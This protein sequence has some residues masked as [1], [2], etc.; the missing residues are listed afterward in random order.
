MFRNQ[1]FFKHAIRNVWGSLHADRSMSIE[2]A[3]VSSIDGEIRMLNVSEYTTYLPKEDEWYNV[4]QIGNLDDCYIGLDLSFD[5]WYRL[6]Y[7]INTHAVNIKVYDDDGR[8]APACMVYMRKLPN[9]NV[10]VAVEI[11]EQ[12]V[13]TTKGKLYMS[14]YDGQ[15]KKTAGYNPN[16]NNVSI[17]SELIV[18][19]SQLQ[20]MINVYREELAK[21]GKVQAYVDGY[22]VAV[23]NTDTA[24]VWQYIDIVRDGLVYKF[25]NIDIKTLKTFDSSLDECRKY[26]VHPS[27][28]ND[29]LNFNNDIEIFVFDKVSGLGMYYYVHYLKDLRQLTHRDLS[30]P[31]DK[32]LTAVRRNAENGHVEKV[33]DLNDLKITL[34][35][36]HSGFPQHLQYEHSL[37]SELYKLDDYLIIDAMAG[38]NSTVHEWVAANLEE[39]DYCKLMGSPFEQITKELVTTT[40][41]YHGITKYAADTPLAPSVDFPK[42]FLLPP[43]TSDSFWVFE[44]NA[45]GLFINKKRIYNRKDDIY[46]AS[47]DTVNYI[48]LIPYDISDSEA[49]IVWNA[50]PFKK[51]NTVNY[52]FYYGKTEGG[53]TLTGEFVDITDDRSKWI[54]GEDGTIDWLFDT[55]RY[56]PIVVHDKW[57]YH[58]RHTDTISTDGLI[59]FTVLPDDKVDGI[60][61]FFCPK[62]MFIMTDTGHRLIPEVDY[63]VE[64][65]HVV[66][67]SK[68]KLKRNGITN[69]VNLD[70][71]MFGVAKEYVTPKH[72]YVVDGMLSNDTTFDLRDSKVFV[73]I[74]DGAI[75]HRDEIVFREDGVATTHNI[76]NGKPYCMY[77]TIIPLR[78]IKSLQYTDYE[79]LEHDDATW[80]AVSEYMSVVKPQLPSVEHNTITDTYRVFSPLLTKL[81]YDLK[82]NLLQPVEDDPNNYISNEQFSSLIRPYEYLLDYEPSRNNVDLEYVSILPHPYEHIIE[83]PALHYS[84]LER[85]NINYLDN[86]VLIKTLISIKD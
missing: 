43:M 82:H 24:N 63:H 68:D 31:V 22:P 8:L 58:K 61:N 17:T 21:T 40:Y 16:T 80:K 83:L 73:P 54:E 78:D 1:W 59:R 35:V 49:P 38:I 51:D 67:Y 23:L 33:G 12:L 79:L 70:I 9:Q 81:I 7:L 6:D 72:G 13:D 75:K 30:I 86:K 28:N 56:M 2:L 48:D 55:D 84:L 57:G 53:K 18:N 34:N 52:R 69:N 42:Q 29:D 71:Y 44:Y 39:S 76:P 45:A 5:R 62:V 41:G 3:K 36:R 11:K 46:R 64:W 27:K 77:P 26:I 47:N 10:I 66:V 65:P 60:Y 20:N 19:N 15:F 85:V 37:I 4:Y 14:V 25:Y 74:I 32:L 50:K